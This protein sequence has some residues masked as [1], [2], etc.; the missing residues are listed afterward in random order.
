M[1]EEMKKRKGGW[2]TEALFEFFVGSFSE[3]MPP[4]IKFEASPSANLWTSCGIDAET[5][6][7]AE[8]L[9]PTTLTAESRLVCHVGDRSRF[10]IF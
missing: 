6:L 1:K 2:K 9:R 10:C 8:P 3:E 5:Q 7:A 4:F